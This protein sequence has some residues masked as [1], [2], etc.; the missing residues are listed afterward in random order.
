M[1]SDFVSQSHKLSTKIQEQH[2]SLLFLDIQFQIMK[3]FINIKLCSWPSGSLNRKQSRRDIAL[4][5]S[6]RRNPS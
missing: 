4:N 2:T 6:T 1:N 5:Q 3:D